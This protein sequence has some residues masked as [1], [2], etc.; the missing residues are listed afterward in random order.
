MAQ[1]CSE[2]SSDF[3]LDFRVREEHSGDQQV[4]DLFP[5]PNPKLD[6]LKFLFMVCFKMFCQSLGYHWGIYFGSVAW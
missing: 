1:D 6:F 2:L 4:F 3:G 5:E